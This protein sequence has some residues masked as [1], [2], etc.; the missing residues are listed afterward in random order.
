MFEEFFLKMS[1]IISREMAER[2]I[3]SSKEINL[4]SKK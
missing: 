2:S 4:K 3:D 1:F